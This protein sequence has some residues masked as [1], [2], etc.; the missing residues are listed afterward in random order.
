MSTLT[1][2]VSVL[3]A[4]T[5][6][7]GAAL[8]GGVPMTQLNTTAHLDRVHHDVGL[9]GILLPP[10]D[11]TLIPSFTQSLKFLMDA[12][13]G[14]GNKTLPGLVDPDGTTTLES[15]LGGS[16]LSLAS[17]GSSMTDVFNQM[18]L[19]DVTL[20]QVLGLLGIDAPATDTMADLMGAGGALEGI[21]GLSLNDLL[22]GLGGMSDVTTVAGLVDALGMG[23]KTVGD[24]LGQVGFGSTSTMGDLFTQLGIPG[25]QG[26]LPMLGA[27]NTTVVG[28][29]LT[30]LGLDP[31]TT[32]LDDLLNPAVAG[33][34]AWDGLLSSV[35][36]MTLGTLMGFDATTTLGGVI[37][38]LHFD[39]NG[40][41]TALGDF[42]FTELLGQIQLNPTDSLATV[43]GN[44]PLGLNGATLGDTSLAGL[45]GV[46]DGGTV[47]DT[48]TLTAF[49]TGAQMDQLT[50][51][52]WIGLGS[53]VDISNWFTP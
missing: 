6:V 16:N 50:L 2:R 38:G 46:M 45:L 26:F 7:A 47:D 25:L 15:L 30:T 22:G 24:L 10:T 43:L 53:A 41:D 4:S 5:A 51:D 39:L 12:M 18:G 31:S 13:L 42:T 28:D 17:G 3:G 48:T 35:G 37:N 32:T 9:V 19:D 21:G 36:G 33:G 11:P 49:L 40:T 14:I 29:F 8:L 27:S 20:G 44:L 34:G 23:T 52:D 1:Q